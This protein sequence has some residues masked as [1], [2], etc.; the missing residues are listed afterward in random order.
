MKFPRFTIERLRTVVLVGGGVLVAAIAVFLIAGQWKLRKLVKDIPGR[1]GVDIQQ[2]ANG[3]DY[4]Q[5]RKGKTLFKIHAARAVQIKSS[6]KSLLHDVRID[7]YGEDG[8]R[9]DTI[10]GSEFEYDPAAGIA[11]AAGTVEITMMR[12]G[13][14]PA[15]AQLKPQFKPNSAQSS[16]TPAQAQLS[17]AITDNEIHVTTSGLVFNQKTGVA[18]TDQRVD[19]AVRQ[20]KGDAIG[21]TYNSQA[22]QLVLDHAVELTA[23]G[24]AT[25]ATGPVTVHAAHAE[26]QRTQQLCILNQAQAQY[27]G[28]SAEATLARLRFR[29]DGTVE[30]MQ[31]SGGVDLHS[32]SG[33]HLTAPQGVMA[34]DEDNHPRTADLTGGTHLTMQTAANPRANG[35]GSS[36]NRDVDGSSPSAHLVFDGKGELRQAHLERGVIFREDQKG[37]SAK[38]GV[39]ESN[40][41]WNSA[42]ADIDFA[43]SESGAAQRGSGKSATGH[44]EARMIHGSGGVIVTSETIANGHP[45]PAKLSA[46]NVVAELAPGS[47][48]T[49]LTGSGHAYFEQQTGQGARQT[50]SSDQ[51]DVRFARVSSVKPTSQTEIQPMNPAR[52]SSQSGAPSVEIEAMHQS[53]HVVLTQTPAPTKPGSAAEQAPMR[54]TAESSDY[55][56]KT[57]TLHLTG[58]AQ[59]GPP[60]VQQGALDMT[61][62]SIDFTRSTGD[63]F[64]RGDVRASWINSGSQ[65]GGGLPGAT[66]LAGPSGS[67]NANNNGPVHAI[68]AEAELRQSTQEIFLRGAP[69]NGAQGN[70]AQARLW[71]AGN[72]VS[73]PLIILNRQKMTLVAQTASAA[74]PV[75]TVLL[76]KAPAAKNGPAINSADH[77][78][79]GSSAGPKSPSTLRIRSGDL[80]YSESERLAVFHGGVLGDVLAETTENGNSATINAQQADVHLAPATAHGAGNTSV[81][82]MTAQGRVNVDFPDRHGTGDRL[83]YLGEDGS[84]TLTGTGANPP[85]MTDAER[86]AVTGAA[87]IYHSRD[88]SVSVEGQGAKTG[89]ETR[90][91][92]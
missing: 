62:Q 13:A 14:R 44:T 58:S 68:A 85:R 63:A 81:E 71:Q 24:S 76:G 92:K 38:G 31:G 33:A 19:F 1:L 43:H 74:S 53:G 35:S 66:L 56:G 41:T 5:S 91:P 9:A 51:L 12:P 6:G 50:S 48:L 59:S 72:S 27:S 61:A 49:H 83:V 90:A 78:S 30:Q 77:R 11:H 37:T 32:A 86:G 26:F 80:R 42:V 17:S 8:Q 89:A 7:L 79:S 16:P 46:D 34:F 84:F 15:I 47:V 2:S 67:S 45:V 65:K 60:R 82:R 28:G 69:G 39:V 3:V 88:R 64:A 4:T 57:E 36:Q 55:D 22:G 23:N 52:L 18:T 25:G 73:A 70:A 10:S 40:R 54:A 75:R 29:E 21:A 20:G 87:L